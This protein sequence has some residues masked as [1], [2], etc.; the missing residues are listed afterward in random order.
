MCK[1]DSAPLLLKRSPSGSQ[2]LLGEKP[3]P[4]LEV[5]GP[6]KKIA[7]KGRRMHTKEERDVIEEKVKRGVARRT[8]MGRMSPVSTVTRIGKTRG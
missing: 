5:V 2:P 6:R 4:S 7:D 8:S 3:R 1:P